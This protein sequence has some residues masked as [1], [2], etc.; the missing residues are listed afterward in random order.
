MADTL[1][2]LETTEFH[3][4]LVNRQLD[5]DGSN[6]LAVIQRIKSSPE[7]ASLPV[8]MIT[9]FADHQELAVQAGAEQGF[10]KRELGDPATREK[11][12][13]FLS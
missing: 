9:N 7:L 2:V 11:L 1:A 10:G 6:G 13:S 5:R 12:A 8:M 4:I 3:L